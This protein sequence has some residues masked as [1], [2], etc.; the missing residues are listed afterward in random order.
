[1]FIV[2]VFEITGLNSMIENDLLQYSVTVHFVL[3]G[4]IVFF[5]LYKGFPF[6]YTQNLFIKVKKC[7]QKN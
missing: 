1:M 5:L 6:P 7:I 2:R 4:A 3:V